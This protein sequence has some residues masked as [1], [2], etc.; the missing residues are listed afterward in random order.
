MFL[1][2]V[3]RRVR[4]VASNSFIVLALLLLAVSVAAQTPTFSGRQIQTGGQYQL[5]ADF[6]GD[7]RA[8]LATAGL[9]V[10]I[11]LGLGNGTF[12][13]NVKYPVGTSLSGITTGDFNGDGVADAIGAAAFGK[14]LIFIGNGDGTFRQAPDVL[15]VQ[16]VDNT[17]VAV[18]DYNGDGI[19]D[20]VAVADANSEF[21]VALGLGDGTFRV[22]T[23]IND[24]M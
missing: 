6:N 22:A 3:A 23:V 11:L 8:D 7:G 1:A 10:E 4:T 18:A 20:F 21:G 2:C 5:T 12:Q 17:D 19:L 9:D 24:P 13:P 14:V 16:N 15:I